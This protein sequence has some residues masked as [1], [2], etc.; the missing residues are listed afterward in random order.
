MNTFIT[1]LLI[2]RVCL[3]I[4]GSGN[5]SYVEEGVGVIE[6]V[7]EYLPKMEKLEEIERGYRGE[8]NV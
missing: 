6:K 4:V 7:V 8:R 2:A 5:Y 3:P 1:I